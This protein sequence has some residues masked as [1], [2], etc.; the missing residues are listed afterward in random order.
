MRDEFYCAKEREIE[1]KDNDTK[2]QMRKKMFFKKVGVM[3]YENRS[4]INGR[5][6][7]IT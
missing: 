6:G 5:C 1:T 3:I 4:C 7:G 2:I